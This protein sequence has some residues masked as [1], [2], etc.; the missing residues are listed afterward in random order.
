ME[1]EEF[2]EGICDSIIIGAAVVGATAVL[3]VSAIE[4][5]AINALPLPNIPFWAIL[6][7]NVAL[8]L[9][10]KGTKE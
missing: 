3:G 6:G 9:L 2:T 1:N 8:P 10:K 4:T 7:L 5:L